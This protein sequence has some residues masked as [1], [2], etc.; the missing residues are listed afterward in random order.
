MNLFFFSRKKENHSGKEKKPMAFSRKMNN[1]AVSNVVVSVALVALSLLAVSVMWVST[2]RVI[3][4]FSPDIDCTGFE[5]GTNIKVDKVC[6]LNEN[7]IFV[8]VKRG[9]ESFE[10]DSLVFSFDSVSFKLEN[11]NFGCTDI[12]EEDFEYGRECEIVGIG[13]TKEYVFNLTGEKM[14][15]GL[16]IGVY[17]SGA[18][19]ICK[20]GNKK[21]SEKC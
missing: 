7:E 2:N 14:F 10:I 3:V 6:Y 20:V 12:R 9:L 17:M 11:K 21:I 19:N 16:D 1:R 8:S 18:G 13:Q 4:S 15:E 5:L